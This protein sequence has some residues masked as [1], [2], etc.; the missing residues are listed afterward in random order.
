MRERLKDF[1]IERVWVPATDFLDRKFDLG[2]RLDALE[3]HLERNGWFWHGVLPLTGLSAAFNTAG[4]ACVASSVAPSLSIT[5]FTVAAGC[6]GLAKVGRWMGGVNEAVKDLNAEL[7]N[8]RFKE[9]L[10]E[11][12]SGEANL[13][14]INEDWSDVNGDRADRL[15]DK[16]FADILKEAEEKAGQ[17]IKDRLRDRK[18][19]DLPPEDYTVISVEES[20]PSSAPQPQAL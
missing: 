7:E 18:A 2:N 6:G 20:S 9:T 11:K 1:L 10:R 8:Q 3:D 14:D 13:H 15:A 17:A 4:W 12:F 5:A 19:I 16:L